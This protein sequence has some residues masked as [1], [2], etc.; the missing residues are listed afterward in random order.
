MRLARVP[1]FIEAP[2]KVP[3]FLNFSK[4]PFIQPQVQGL[5]SVFPSLLGNRIEF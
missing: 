3:D 1:D 4:F 2:A 5:E